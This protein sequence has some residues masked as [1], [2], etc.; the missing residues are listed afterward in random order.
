MTAVASSSSSL[1]PS[2][3]A[4]SS[5]T[6]RLEPL[7]LVAR[8]TKPRGAAAA[9][10][11]QQAIAAP[12][13]FFFAELFDVAGVAE[14]ASS[15]DSASSS[16]LQIAYQ[17]LCLFAY[18]T[19]SDYLHLVQSGAIPELS[20]DQIQKL[21]QLT[22]LSLAFQH[23]SLPYATLYGSLGVQSSNSRELEDLIIEAIYAGLIS[24][25]LNELQTRFEV[26]HVQGR[27]FP[28]PSILSQPALAALPSIASSTGISQLDSVF[29]SLQNWQATTVSVLESLQARMDSTRSSAADSEHQ[30]QQHRRALLHNL[31]EAQQ[32]LEQQQQQQQLRKS[33]GPANA[34]EI[35]DDNPR[36]AARKKA[37]VAG[38]RGNKRSRA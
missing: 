22:L 12:G 33:K 37:A 31:V 29:T 35:D 24:G 17:L 38:A 8:S 23:K 7:L 5:S 34:M 18:G 1:A 30:R 2:G 21:R 19:Y 10:L 36:S 25:K 15:S 6:S 13:V 3:T 28:H 20:R 4:P 14:L 27:D 9:S 16:Q 32:E 26:H 11:V